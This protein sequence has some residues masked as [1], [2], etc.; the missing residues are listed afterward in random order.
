[1]RTHPPLTTKCRVFSY[2]L[3][4]KYY[5][6]GNDHYL[7]KSVLLYGCETWKTSKIIENKLQVF[8][9]RCLRKILRII[10]PEIIPIKELWE[11]SGLKEIKFEIKKR[12][13]NWIGHTL[14]K[15]NGLSD[16]TALAWNPQGNRRR[17]RPKQTWRR[18][19][20]EEIEEEGK[21]W[22]EMKKLT[23]NRTH[24]RRFVDAPARK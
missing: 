10:W 18:T 17:G 5:S 1:M 20:A 23:Q 6:T 9:N 16:K 11:K 2:F 19:V 13:W 3:G 15:D 24:W 12:K 22:G 7:V 21:T 4:R 14:R 8:I